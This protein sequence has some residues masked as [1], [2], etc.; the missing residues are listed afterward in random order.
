M[1]RGRLTVPDVMFG[2]MAMAFLGALYPVIA[3]GMTANATVIPPAAD[4]LLTLFLPL[5]LLVFFSTI[6]LKAAR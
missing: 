1:D 2:L 6:Y 4:M 3:D 5:L